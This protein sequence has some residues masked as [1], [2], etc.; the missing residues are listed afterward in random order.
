MIQQV[1]GDIQCL[2]GTLNSYR[3][4]CLEFINALD[5]FCINHIPREDNKRANMLA[6]Q[7][8]GYEISNG[9]FLTKKKSVTIDTRMSV[10]ESVNGHDVGC[11]EHE[12]RPTLHDKD[13]Q[14][15]GNS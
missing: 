8:S 6:Q 4:R 11:G 7:A 12:R 5:T 10:V 3:E 1:K 14:L 15:A 13:G 2:D 9:V